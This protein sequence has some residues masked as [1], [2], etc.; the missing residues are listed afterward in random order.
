MYKP[1]PN[2]PLGSSD[3]GFAFEDKEVVSQD[4]TAT[5]TP[6]EMQLS[7]EKSTFR[8]GYE[9]AKLGYGA[10][11]EA[12]VFDKFYSQYADYK[13]NQKYYDAW[14]DIENFGPTSSSR[15]FHQDAVDNGVFD[16]DENGNIVM[17]ENYYNGAELIYKQNALKGALLAK[18]NGLNEEQFNKEYAAITDKKITELQD[19]SEGKKDFGFFAGSL[20]G[21]LAQPET[22]IEFATPGRIVGSTV[23]GG[24]AKAFGTEFAVGI[25]SET[26]REQ[27]IREHK[28][29]AG[30]E[31]G[32]WD[33]VQGI[34]LNAGL[35]GTFRGIGSAVVDVNILRKIDSKI[36]DKTDKEI[37][38]RWARRENYKLTSD[39]QKH[40]ALMEKARSDIDVGRPVDIAQHTDIDINTKIDEQIEEVS[41][42]REL[43]STEANIASRESLQA[44]EKEIDN[45][46][47]MV[48]TPEDVFEGMATEKEAND[49]F[50]EIAIDDAE[51]KAELE[52]I[53]QEK[54]ALSDRA[55]QMKGSN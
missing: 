21:Q 51:F 24:A 14:R 46:E 6:A 34:L 41:L 16:L 10:E 47:P 29:R 54:K 40:L 7:Q 19:L 27:R 53:R 1:Q 35:A 3:A 12:E 33:S 18:R 39:T 37:F 49:L 23:M 11:V 25:V 50:D 48:K 15:S 4:N 28:A 2:I 52:E 9:T 45:T 55:Q 30:L 17:G 22:A 8:L 26:L 32:L 20:A 13:D 44:I 43:Q 42:E 31:Y 38:A 5:M 36:P